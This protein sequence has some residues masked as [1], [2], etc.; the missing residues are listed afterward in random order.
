M[1]EWA[2]RAGEACEILA[3]TEGEAFER[4]YFGNEFC[5]HRLPLAADLRNALQV[6]E[7]HDLKLSLVTPVVT[8]R[9]LLGV[10]RLLQVLPARSEV[11]FNDWGVLEMLEG[12]RPV[13]GRMLLRTLQEP[14]A[15]AD[16][17]QSDLAQ[18]AFLRFLRARGIERV[19]TDLPASRLR[20]RLEK[21][22]CTLHVP[23]THVASGRACLIGSLHVKEPYR[24]KQ[25]C[26]TTWAELSCGAVPLVHRGNTAFTR[27]PQE[28]LD[29]L[30]DWAPAA[31]IDRVVYDRELTF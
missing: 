1:I 11:I 30:L 14:R 20:G 29:R 31:G 27:Q 21:T 2:V 8:D 9:G 15:H 26:R 23:F 12:F 7:R 10:E 3:R 17:A 25:E 16:L 24:C 13:L 18:P 28:D 4:I 19:E 22:R 6:C 5:E